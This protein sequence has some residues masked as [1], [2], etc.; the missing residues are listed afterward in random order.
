MTRHFP[1]PSVRVLLAL[2]AAVFCIGT[3]VARAVESAAAV[4]VVYHVDDSARAIGAL[5]SIT[6]HLKAAP[7]TKIVVVTL[8][9]GVDFLVNGAKD[10]R[11]NPY[12]PMIDDLVSVGVEFKACNNTLVARR[13]EKGQL[14]PDV[15]VVESGVAEITRL[16]AEEGYAYLKP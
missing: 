9:D 1:W 6:N 14:H 7:N 4:K 3:S 11:G 15:S 12:E 2:L 8:A 13:I 5:R 10:P 16:Q